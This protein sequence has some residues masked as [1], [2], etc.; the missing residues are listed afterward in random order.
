MLLFWIIVLGLVLALQFV[1]LFVGPPYLPTLAKQ[2]EAALDLLDL[3]PG[4][5]F[6][7]LGCG[8]G[9]MLKAAAKRGL[10]VVGY[11]I[12]P[13]LAAIAWLRTRRYGSSVR[14]ICGNFWK[15]PLKN[16]DGIFVFLSDSYMV[17]LDKFL[18]GQ[19][20]RKPFKLASYA[21]PVPERELEAKSGPVFLYKYGLLAKEK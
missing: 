8:D 17:K 10:V 12:N 11:E 3:K 4:Q 2:R 9:T 5:T 16:V 6:I 7:D 18:S 13:L 14:I 21:F 20:F 1:V 19:K 15:K